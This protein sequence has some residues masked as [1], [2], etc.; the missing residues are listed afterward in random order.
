MTKKKH[1][2]MNITEEEHRKWH[3]EHS[4][5]TPEKHKA[6][7]KKMGITEKEDREWHKTHKTLEETTKTPS[8]K[9]LNCFAIGGGFLDYC[10]KQG[11]L[12]REG[13]GRSV[14]Y[15]ATSEGKEELK[16]FDIKI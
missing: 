10:V 5:I 4:E 11:W 12:I 7:M 2:G 14:K 3:E 1:M 15:Y 16:K 9:P 13:K 8:R 6:L